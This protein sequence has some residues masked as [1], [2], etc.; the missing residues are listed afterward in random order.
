MSRRISECFLDDGK[1]AVHVQVKSMCVFTPI[2]W[3]KLLAVTAV[4]PSRRRST[5]LG[6]YHRFRYGGL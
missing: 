3:T 6:L 5:E 2:D 4:Y 1:I